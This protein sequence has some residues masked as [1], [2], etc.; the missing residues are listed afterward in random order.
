[1][2]HLSLW[3]G[4]ALASGIADPAGARSPLQT[5]VPPPVEV[6]RLSAD[7]HVGPVVFT[8]AVVRVPQGTTYL[9]V[10]SGGLCLVDQTR[11]WNQSNAAFAPDPQLKAL[12]N[13]ELEAAGF[14]AA[15]DPTSLFQDDSE[16][17]ADFEVGAE[18][19]GIQEELCYQAAFLVWGPV[20]LR[21]A[22]RLDAVWQVYSRRDRK[23]LARIVTSGGDE[24]T[25]MGENAAEVLTDR[26]IVQNIRALLNSNAFRAAISVR[27]STQPQ[28]TGVAPPDPIRLSTATQRLT[29]ADDVGS[30]VT[31][32]QGGVLGSGWIVGDGYVLTNQHVVGDTTQVRIRWSDGLE[33]GGEVA[34]TDVHRDVAL[35]RV[36][37][38]GRPPLKIRFEPVQ[39]GEAVFA[40]GTPYDTSLQNTVTRGAVSAMRTVDGFSFI[41]SDVTVNP[42]NSGGPLVDDKGQVVGMTDIG[43]TP[44]GAPAGLNLFIPVR[45]ALDF[46]GLKATPA[47]TAKN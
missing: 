18:V 37:T 28:P 39:P 25:K 41:Q 17:A 6:V 13:H 1:V 4:L 11:A 2:A 20:S 19:T 30:V 24:E 3:C 47:A 26:A 21:G 22:L 15:G 32:L 46:L 38:R 14:K 16:A 27:S 12:F 45:D 40:I 8:R 5:K 7:A 35:I 36:D 9:S 29:V 23:V 34:R 43:L 31:V 33:S 44:E 10:E 42:G